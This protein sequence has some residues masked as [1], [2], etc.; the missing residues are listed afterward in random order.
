MA[1]S[2]LSNHSLK[3]NNISFFYDQAAVFKN[4]SFECKAKETVWLRGSSGSG[5]STFLKLLS[6]LLKVGHGE[7]L[8]GDFKMDVDSEDERARFRRQHIAFGDQDLHLIEAWT[9]LQNLRLVEPVKPLCLKALKE[10]HLEELAERTIKTLSGGQKQK[11]LLARMLLQNPQIVL[12]DEPTAHL[13][14][15]S[16][17]VVMTVIHKHFADATTIIVSHDQRLSAWIPKTATLQGKNS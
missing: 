7:I 12:L 4:F 15:A 17:E 6:G 2:N 10:L 9:V 14:D 1:T 13:D 8:W 3:V 11:V 5:K 16:T